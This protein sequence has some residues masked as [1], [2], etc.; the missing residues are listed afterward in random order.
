MQK[1]TEIRETVVVKSRD[2]VTG[3]TVEKPL[4]RFR[5]VPYVDGWPRFGHYLLD[6][7]FILVLNLILGATL[8]VLFV[9][10]DTAIDFDDRRV[11]LFSRLFNWLILT[12]GYYFLFEYSMGTSPAKAILGRVVVDEYGNK[13]TAR[14]LLGRSFARAVPFEG[15]SCL[16]TTGWHDRWSNTFVIRK[17]DLEEL[18]L[19][20]KVQNIGDTSVSSQS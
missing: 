15:L 19:L 7:V 17:K 5:Q 9:V 11:D 1:I 8:G 6:T 10:F 3:E 12:P 4:T 13:P 20:Q 2:R 16:S 18:K 14:Q